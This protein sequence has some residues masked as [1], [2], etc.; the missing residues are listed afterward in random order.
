MS[1]RAQVR[2]VPGLPEALEWFEARVGEVRDRLAELGVR[3]VM[4][5]HH[6]DADGLTAAAA[7]KAALE[8]LGLSVRLICLEKL[9]P[10]VV[11]ALHSS[12]GQAIFYCDIGSPHADL[13]SEA[14]GGRNLTVILDHHD[15]RPAKDPLVLD[16]NLE[17]VGLRGEEDFSGA[18]CCYLFARTLDEA[19]KDLSYLALVGSCEIPV[20]YKGLN[21]QVLEEALSEG[22]VERVGKKLMIKKLGIEVRKLFSLLQVLGPVGYYV[23][24]PELGV[25]AALEGI[26][27]E[28]RRMAEELEA[29]RKAVNKRLLATL[30][31]RGLKRDGRIQW[32]DAGDAYRGMG[33]KVI[34][35]FCSYLSHQRKLVRP[36]MFVVGLMH[37]E[38]TVPGFGRLE[39]DFV[40]VSVRAPKG[41]R[42]EI[43]AG[44][45]PTAVG[46]LEEATRGFGIAVDGHAYAASCVIPADKVEEFIRRAAAVSSGQR[47]L[48][49]WL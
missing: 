25:R 38:P 6:D 18:T 2:Q 35:T 47:G 26:T 16:L 46:L 3:E 40:K 28:V 39:G 4:L 9:F 13:I 45:A 33:S 12:S 49:A 37:M 41:L 15:P 10:G 29:K 43:D 42:A 11:R 14:N 21:A 5:V 34:G 31:R 22:V 30:Y 7:T 36:D 8:R 48:G 27:D 1:A 23:G 44:R 20:G 17:H 32:F 24:G 19:N